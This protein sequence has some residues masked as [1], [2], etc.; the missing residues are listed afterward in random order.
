L[1][2]AHEPA[3]AKWIRL[4]GN[5]AVAERDI[6]RGGFQGK[7]RPVRQDG[8]LGRT[9]PDGIDHA[10]GMVRCQDVRARR[11]G[12][13]IGLRGDPQ[14]QGTRRAMA[15][16]PPLDGFGEEIDVLGTRSQ[17]RTDLTPLWGNVAPVPARTVADVPGR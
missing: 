16:C 4:E 5:S 11:P 13:G 12:E 6:S 10:L 2:L 15:L 14:D 3:M 9:R 1:K 8:L 7:V 17:R